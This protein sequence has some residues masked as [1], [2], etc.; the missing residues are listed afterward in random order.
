MEIK[1]VA[2]NVRL[3]PRKARGT[4]QSVKK[5]PV[6]VAISKLTLL[7]LKGGREI[8]GVLK[9]AVA[10]ASVKDQ[11]KTQNLQIKNILI[12]E[13]LKM[14]RRDKSHGAR[15]GGGVIQKKTSHITVILEGS[16]G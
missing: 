7:P 13:G 4:A 6:E 14:K 16:N 10:N 1:A 12:D 3:S 11:S 5:L 8:L 9:S 15:Y 2:K